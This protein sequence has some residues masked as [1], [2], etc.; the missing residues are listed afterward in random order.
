[1]GA[2]PVALYGRATA[3]HRV[4]VWLAFEDAYDKAPADESLIQRVV[5]AMAYGDGIL[6]LFEF[7]DTWGVA[8]RPAT[9]RSI[10]SPGSPAAGCAAAR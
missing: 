2:A 9:S 5:Y 3:H 1:M 8:R 7:E 10:C 6:L 4:E